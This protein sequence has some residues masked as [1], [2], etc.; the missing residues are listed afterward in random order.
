MGQWWPAG[1]SSP[2][3]NTSWNTTAYVLGVEKHLC[4][5]ELLGRKASS[6]GDAVFTRYTLLPIQMVHA[7]EYRVVFW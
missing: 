5:A 6:F 2:S 1:R 4:V 3:T 7:Q